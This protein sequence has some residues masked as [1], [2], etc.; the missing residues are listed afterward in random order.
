MSDRILEL[1]K[2]S[3]SPVLLLVF[4]VASTALHAVVL[5]ALPEVSLDR[6]PPELT[7][8]EVVLVQTTRSALPPAARSPGEDD[9]R[10]QVALADRVPGAKPA[11]RPQKRL[12]QPTR[13]ILTLPDVPPPESITTPAEIETKTPAAA[14]ESAPRVA[15][16]ALQT[17]PSFSASY[18]RNPAPRY[19]LA[20]RR[21]GEQGTVTLKVLVASDGLPRR[22]EIEKT[23]GSTHLDT[24]ALEA[25]RQWRFVP[26]RRGPVQIES[27]ILV[28]VVFRL[29]SPS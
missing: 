9:A 24:A 14:P 27:W 21:A 25:V 4:L 13:A 16:L 20:A 3:R 1:A 12:R 23:S 6:S 26:A 22:I 8:V 7:V 2:R 15:S 29:E 18:L 10:S 19:P 17:P 5:L 28:P 11:H